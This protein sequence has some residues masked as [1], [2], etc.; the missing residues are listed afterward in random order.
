MA[1]LSFGKSAG[2]TNRRTSQRVQGGALGQQGG[3]T[4]LPT[5][6]LELPDVEPSAVATDVYAR[7]T[8]LQPAA[9]TQA[10]YTRPL[11]PTSISDLQRLGEALGG[12]N[13]NLQNLATTTVDFIGEREKRLKAEAEEEAAGTVFGTREYKRLRGGTEELEK[14]SQDPEATPEQRQQA[15]EAL[16]RVQAE[17]STNPHYPSALRRLQ[18]QKRAVG[19]ANWI[20]S[21]PTVTDAEGNERTLRELKPSSPEFSNA[22]NDYVY[23]GEVLTP[24]EARK[25]QPVL[26]QSL[27]V[28]QST[29]SRNHRAYKKEQLT[30]FSNQRIN[31]AVEAYQGGGTYEDLGRDLQEGFE[32]LGPKGDPTLTLAESRLAQSN[33]ISDVVTALNNSP[34]RPKSFDQVL[35]LLSPLMT[36]PVADRFIDGKVNEKLRAI[37]N[38]DPSELARLQG[39]WERETSSRAARAREQQTLNEDDYINTE[40]VSL[41]ELYD[42]GAD[43]VATPQSMQRFQEAKLDL[44][45]KI[46]Q[47]NMADP[48]RQTRL[49]KLLDTRTAEYPRAW[50]RDMLQEFDKGYN[51]DLDLLMADPSTQDAVLNRVQKAYDDGVLNSQQ[52][53]QK[54]AEVRRIMEGTFRDSSKAM[55]EAI[56]RVEDTYLNNAKLSE[57]PGGLATDVETE[58]FELAKPAM[59]RDGRK[60]MRKLAQEG[61]LDEF[62]A[63]YSVM[64]EQKRLEYG[65]YGSTKDPGF[66]EYQSLNDLQRAHNQGMADGA[67]EQRAQSRLPILSLQAVGDVMDMVSSG[68]PLPPHIA[69]AVRA[70]GGLRPFIESE[71]IK[72]NVKVDDARKAARERPAEFY[73]VELEEDAPVVQEVS[74]VDR[75]VGGSIAL[76]GALLPGAPAQATVLPPPPIDRPLPTY[77]PGPRQ[78]AIVAAAKQVGIRPIDLAA[79]MSYETIGSFDPSITNQLGYSGLIQ[80]SPDNQE[81][82]GVTADSTFEEQAQAAARYLK[83]RGVRPGDGI[84]RIY[85]AILVG[86]ADGKLEDGSDGMDATDVN[87]NSVNSALKDLLPGGG[88][89]QNADRFLRGD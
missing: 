73:E 50:R 61:R 30:A 80:F 89:Y 41:N 23:G 24:R 48:A 70:Y 71:L 45:E 2:N 28:A 12:F 6:G 62:P 11:P 29:Q 19:I 5:F 49:L 14:A 55:T 83:D 78:Q 66:V 64:L 59:M 18:V 88:H 54:Q 40:I 37:N 15:K 21:N 85:A 56:K 52:Y 13:R 31:L 79:A 38:M 84:N 42:F 68:K 7:P 58:L 9:R 36:G 81:T 60:L 4:P 72:N 51:E 16:E 39:Q 32:D 20:D 8:E 43:G 1:K 69:D 76:V 86:N 10:S 33:Y 87:G 82:Y 3:T 74:M 63:Q 22:V 17:A 53:N 57:S 47:E 35:G 46:M 44:Q 67:L 77:G 75:L 27:S 25:L 26:L 34:K 65:L